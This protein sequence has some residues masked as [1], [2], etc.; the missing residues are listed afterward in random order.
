MPR[1]SSRLHVPAL[2]LIALGFLSPALATARP[3][4]PAFPP[5]AE[6][7]QQATPGFVSQL[8]DLLS[9]LWSENGSILDPN[10]TH[11]GPPG[12][13]TAPNGSTGDTGAGLEPN[14]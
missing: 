10:G 7:P 2:A 12:S 14:G 3:Q 1:L 6:R 9:R 5:T 8:R 13:G 4:G 11:A